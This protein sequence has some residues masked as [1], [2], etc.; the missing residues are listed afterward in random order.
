MT[1]MDKSAR[2]DALGPVEVDVPVLEGML[3]TRLERGDSAAETMPAWLSLLAGEVERMQV[4][5][6]VLSGESDGQY[7]PVATWPAEAK[8]PAPLMEAAQQAL[9]TVR[10]PPF[11][12]QAGA[13]DLSH[14]L[15]SSA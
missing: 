14:W 15:P 12:P 3:W 1:V 9:E 2:A 11:R 10:A 4:G 8:L 13:P 6:V 7:A 5:V